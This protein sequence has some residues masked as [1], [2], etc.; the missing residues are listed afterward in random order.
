VHRTPTQPH[1]VDTAELSQEE[2]GAGAGGSSGWLPMDGHGHVS[3]DGH[4]L[5]AFT[6]EVLGGLP[7]REPF[8]F[9]SPS[10][11]AIH[12]LQASLHTHF[13]AEA[14][15]VRTTAFRLSGAGSHPSQLHVGRATDARA[16]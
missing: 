11:Q 5:A 7:E 3:V 13:D 10:N 6:E 9:F 12:E 14:A 15:Q 4:R 16:C 2:D 8:T 1:D